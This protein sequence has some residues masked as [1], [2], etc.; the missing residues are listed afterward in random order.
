M[1]SKLI[2]IP[3]KL[4][5][6]S[7]S[8]LLIITYLSQSIHR[9]TMGVLMVVF[10]SIGLYFWTSLLEAYANTFGA[11]SSVILS[12]MS[13]SKLPLVI[14]V[15]SVVLGVFSIIRRKCHPG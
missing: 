12:D 13:S 9:L 8:K 14:G 10:G 1:L 5:V 4:I 11:Y 3:L 2:L 6:Y 15:L 7:N